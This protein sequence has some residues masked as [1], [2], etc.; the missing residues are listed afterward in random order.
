MSEEQS[1]NETPLDTAPFPPKIGS[2]ASKFGPL[3]RNQALFVAGSGTAASMVAYGL[4]TTIRPLSSA[5][6]VALLAFLA[7][8]GMGALFGF[9]KREGLP[10]LKYW[11]LKLAFRQRPHHL[12]GAA[13]QQFVQLT[14]LTHDML[15]VPD[16]SFV[17]V[18]EVKGVNLALRSPGEQRDYVQN[19][20]SFLNGLDHEVQVITRPERFDPAPYAEV[21]DARFDQEEDET[22]RHQIVSYTNFFTK[23]TAE[24]LDRKFYL[25]VSVHRG[26]LI[27][28][29]ESSVPAPQTVLYRRASETLERR[30]TVL[31]DQLVSSGL[32]AEKLEGSALV[33]LLRSYYRFG[34]NRPEKVAS[35]R[36]AIAPERVSLYPDHI[37]VGQEYVR[38]FEVNDFPS[39]LPY[40]FLTSLLTAPFRV[41]VVLHLRPVSHELA[42]KLLKNEISRLKVELLGQREKGSVQTTALEHQ[43]E[44]FE[45]LER[46]LIRQEERLFQMS[47]VIAARGDT[48]ADMEALAARIQS[49]L[50]SLM[51]KGRPPIFRPEKAYQ[52]LLP[53]ARDPLEGEYTLPSTSLATMYPFI[54]G[55]LAQP[56]GILYG[57]NE[58]NGTP[59][60]FDR[61]SLENYNTCIFGASG[62]GKSYLA[63][64]EVL[65]QFMLHPTLRVFIIDPLREFTE[66][67]ETLGGAVLRI[68]PGQATYLNPLWVGDNA[69]ERA[70]HA[71]SFFEVLLELKDEERA[72]LDGT[73]TRMYRERRQ[74]FILQ[75]L[76]D[77]L[78]KH[79]NPLG[80][81][82][83]L[84][85]DPYV[86]GSASFLNHPTSVDLN[87]RIVTF[88]LN[89][90]LQQSRKVLVPVMHLVL[91]F[92]KA[93][94][95][96]DLEPKLVVVDE[97]WYLMGHPE[98]AQALS[99]LSR[100][101]RHNKT[102]LT[103][104]SQTAE[105]FLNSDLGRVILTN[106]SLT[107][108]FRHKNVG[109][110]M[111][112]YFSLAP[113]EV[114]LVR[115]AKTGKDVGYS[116]CLFITGTTHS[117]MRVLSSD[118]EHTL[119]TTNPDEVKERDQWSSGRARSP[120]EAFAHSSSSLS[121]STPRMIEPEET[122]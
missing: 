24:A 65:R 110:T 106:S 40:G 19:F 14:D 33:R 29:K 32:Q 20:Q 2:L 95:A 56:T 54:T 78:V 51:I 7:I 80:A 11:A 49:L 67:T 1:S 120:D 21:L 75:D 76:A 39:R 9:V 43:V 31:T 37:V 92:M 86:D 27:G 113:A 93:R 15:V 87:A 116:T 117:P 42:Q 5:I 109:A 105:D 100:H 46:A 70:E 62:S 121:R 3:D 108:L 13:S 12:S 68:G 82:L 99:N 61:F 53:T 6:G 59:L 112:E 58:L 96:A 16:G 89:G 94:C 71:R 64:L 22:I 119:I 10:V 74:E 122:T 118:F 111:R 97:A 48:F 4:L 28:P 88:D 107:T 45:D 63:K 25:A 90:L 26:E 81:R 84:L 47:L 18:L 102:G 44:T 104:I 30:V 114:S 115:F 103:L 72:I 69:S 66:V 50:R 57:F 52:A 36:D 35:V 55:V 17:K 60:I 77:E 85:L 79:E 41:D 101:S 83:S 73:L 34:Q 8:F 38:V 98:S 91:E 23:V